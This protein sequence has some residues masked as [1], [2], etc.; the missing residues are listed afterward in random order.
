MTR[1][2]RC[3]RVSRHLGLLDVPHA[4][5]LANSVAQAREQVMGVG[6]EI[7]EN[8]EPVSNPIDIGDCEWR[9]GRVVE[10]DAELVGCLVVAQAT[11]ASLLVA[12]VAHD[13][14]KAP[15]SVSDQIL[16]NLRNVACAVQHC[17]DGQWIATRVVHHQVGV[18]APGLQGP[19]GQIQAHMANA[20]S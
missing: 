6:L 8:L 17:D 19:L 13:L 15:M 7:T 14:S 20:G 16:E 1:L 3:S 12:I 10:G 9:D 18:H 11:S 2:S 4:E 5:C